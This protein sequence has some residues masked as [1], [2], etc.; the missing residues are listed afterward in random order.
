MNITIKHVLAEVTIIGVLL[1]VVYSMSGCATVP[2]MP[3]DCMTDAECYNE[4][5]TLHPAEE[6]E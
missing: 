1:A 3:T 2:H 5:I 4:C 6:C